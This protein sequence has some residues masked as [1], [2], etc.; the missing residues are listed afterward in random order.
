MN[1]DTEKE[2]VQLTEERVRKIVREEIV[3][4]R[5]EALAAMGGV[6][7]VRNRPRRRPESDFCST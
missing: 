5:N 4:E 7:S 1:K 6:R 3:R 2:E